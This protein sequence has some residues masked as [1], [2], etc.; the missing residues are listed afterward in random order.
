MRAKK[1]DENQAELVGQ[2]R[3]IGCSVFP[4]HTIGK[5]FPDIVVGYRGVNYLFEIK[6]GKKSAS[7]KKLTP[8][9]VDFHRTWAGRVWIIENLDQALKILL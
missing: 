2:L 9:E 8:D 1:V 7:R 6:D 4:T 5:G 3:Q